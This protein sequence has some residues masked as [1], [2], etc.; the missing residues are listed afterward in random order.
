VTSLGGLSQ[1]AGQ[2]RR[3]DF[4]EQQIGP[5]AVVEQPLEIETFGDRAGAESAEVEDT[6]WLAAFRCQGCLEPACVEPIGGSRTAEHQQQWHAPAGRFAIILRQAVKT[7]E[8]GT[9]KR[10][11]DVGE[12]VS[13]GVGQAELGGEEE[14]CS[15]GKRGP[16]AT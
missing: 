2:V 10:V 1:L 16:A 4:D 5:D 11:C 7:G 8:P 6:R 14:Y 3:H 12:V 9:V 15:P 13:D